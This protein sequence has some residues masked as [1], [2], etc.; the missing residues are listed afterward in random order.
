MKYNI[1]KIFLITLLIA[2]SSSLASRVTNTITSK[3]TTKHGLKEALVNTLEHS[4]KA[5]ASIHELGS[6]IKNAL[7]AYTNREA[8]DQKSI[9]WQALDSDDSKANFE[10]DILI[11]FKTLFP[12]NPIYNDIVSQVGKNESP[13]ALKKLLFQIYLN[14]VYFDEVDNAILSQVIHSKQSQSQIWPHPLASLVCHGGRTTIIF[15]KKQGFKMD[16][17]KSALF[18][19]PNLIKPRSAASHK[20]KFDEKTGNLTEEKIIAQ[21]AL[22]Y[23]KSKFGKISHYSMNF[24]IG[25]VGNFWPDNTNII[26]PEGF[27]IVKKT[28]KGK[29]KFEKIGKKLQHGHMYLRFQKLNKSEN[30]SAFMFGLENEQPGAKGMFS[31]KAH[32]ALSALEDASKLTSIS[33][34]VKWGKMKGVKIPASNGGRAVFLKKL[35]FSVFDKIES[36][37]L[38]LKKKVWWIILSSNNQQFNDFYSN[39][40]VKLSESEINTQLETLNAKRRL[41][42]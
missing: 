11:I 34:G 31:G 17:L 38:E 33:G 1:T 4:Y 35:D 37:A 10:R 29:D 8:K 39:Y 13:E 36:Y 12:E 14:G 2:I 40:L 7:K 6:F 32:N 20:L 3:S 41:F 30:H 22:D 24:S 27:S 21:A 42:K 28:E 5:S 26:G 18:V 16:Q 9:I 25:G 19:D 23:F 15:D